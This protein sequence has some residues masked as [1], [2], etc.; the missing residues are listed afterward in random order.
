MMSLSSL[1]HQKVS[2]EIF[3]QLRAFLA[4]KPCQ[5]F[6][7]PLDVRLFPKA[8][9]SDAYLVQPDLFVVCDSL[10]LEANVSVPARKRSL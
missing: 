10:K 7:A 8:D 5:V 2:G 1:I 6:A 4:G 9:S 3:F